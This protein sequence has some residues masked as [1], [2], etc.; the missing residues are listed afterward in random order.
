MK[1][2][3][4]DVHTHNDRY[5]LTL[6]VDDV[7]RQHEGLRYEQY[8]KN[9]DVL[10]MSIEDTGIAWG[11]RSY[12]YKRIGGSYGGYDRHIRHIMH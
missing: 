11:Y 9:N 10:C 3:E 12:V 7:P 1:I 6:Y 8:N 4:I 2:H 5:V